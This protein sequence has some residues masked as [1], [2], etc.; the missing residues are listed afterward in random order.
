MAKISPDL[1]AWTCKLVGGTTVHWGAFALRFQ[2]HEFKT[3]TR[4]GAMAG[5]NL[6]D[7]PIDL[8]EL[9]P[10]YERAETRMGVTG[11]HGIPRLPASSHGKVLFAGAKKLGYTKYMTTNMA[12]NSVPRDGR[13]GASRPA[14]ACRAAL[15]ARNGPR[16]T[17]IFRRPKPPGKPKCAPNR[18]CCASSTTRAAK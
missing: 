6:L 10:Y 18:R 4:Y 3:R 5:A 14:S 17:S 12:I 2:E 1:P 9:E 15:S 16:F 13:A 7:W 11:T 8:K